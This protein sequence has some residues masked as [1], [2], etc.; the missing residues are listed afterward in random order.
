MNKLLSEL[1]TTGLK[2]KAVKSAGINVAAQFIGF[3]CHTFGV[4]VLAR[5]LTP[6][7]FGLVAM[8]TA[9]SL[10]VM[11]FGINGFTEYI[12]QKH[13]LYLEEIN[14][15]FWLQLGL[16]CSLAVGFSFF[17]FF[18]VNFYSEPTLSGIA[19]AMTSSFIFQALST[20]HLALLKREMKFSSIAV[21]ELIA[22]IMSVF[23]AI[24]AAID[25][26]GYWAIVT[27]QLSVPAVTMI[28]AWILCPWRPSRPKN[29][30]A[31]LPGLK[32][33]IQVYFNFSLGYVTR[34]I[35]K[36][37][38]GKFYGS[39]ILGNY[40]RAYHLS[41]MP[42]N[43]LLTPL[44]GIALSTLSR[45]RNDEIRFTSYFTKAVS[46]VALMGSISAAVLTLTAQDLIP[47]LLG[48]DWREAGRVVMVFGPGIAPMLVYGTHSWLHLALG[49][50]DRWLR[51]NIFATIITFAAFLI[52]TPFGAVAMALAYS[53]ISFILFIPALW[54]AG[55]PVHLRVGKILSSI[56]PFFFSAFLVSVFWLY[57]SESWSPWS[58]YLLSL[59][60][61]TR[62]CITTFFALILYILAVIAC[63]R[64]LR[65]FH[66]IFSLLRLMF[67]R[68]QS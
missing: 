52:A 30:S 11:N 10:W 45:L 65:S 1:S 12:I 23:F 5:L 16:A 4:I 62:I 6:T 53:V 3:L 19:I 58:G 8:V 42:A 15:I 13:Q 61:L 17:G 40:D 43:Q 36:V 63:Q 14:S 27:R 46:T 25:G 20:N 29:L 24:A 64:N 59:S 32:Y 9:F 60:P 37:L 31:A 38:L 44:H 50:P 67:S 22:V 34:N 54:Y 18:L 21:A 7:D 49:K 2:T 55:I 48:P 28:A 26:L 68:Q 47:F 41:S 56:C 57:F 33:A 51:W 66:D 35:D 39:D